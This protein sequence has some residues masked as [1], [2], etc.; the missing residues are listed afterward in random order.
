MLPEPTKNLMELTLYKHLATQL[1]LRKI[2]MHAKG[3]SIEFGDDNKVDPSF[4]IGLLQ[5]QPQVYRMDGPNKLKFAM[6]SESAKDRLA[7]IKLLIEQL[8]Q[9]RIGE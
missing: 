3:G 7:L 5:N 6:P 4:I 8:S 1:G 2:E 9:H